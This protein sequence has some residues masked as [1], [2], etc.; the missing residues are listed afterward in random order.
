VT[1]SGPSPADSRAPAPHIVR[2]PHLTGIMA[3]IA[4]RRLEDHLRRAGAPVLIGQVGHGIPELQL[5]R[6][7]IDRVALPPATKSIDALRERCERLSG[8][9]SMHCGALDKALEPVRTGRLIRIVVQTDEADAFCLSVVPGQY[10][11]GLALGLEPGRP[12][13]D[14]AA[15]NQV[16][17]DLV[18]RWR[19][20]DLGLPSQN[21]GGLGATPRRQP[22]PPV[23]LVAGGSELLGR[24]LSR[25]QGDLMSTLDQDTVHWLALLED[26]KPEP[27]IDQFD[28][29]DVQA[30]WFQLMSPDA[31]RQFYG[32][33]TANAHAK[34]GMFA[35]AVRPVMG[36]PIRNLL[37]DVESG[38][39][40]VRPLSPTDCLV[41][42]TLDQ[43][44][45]PDFEAAM[46][47]LAERVADD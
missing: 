39:I 38:A 2:A 16:M 10:V 43:R 28:V 13:T 6:F 25:L 35:R 9:L 40:G 24:V 45:V 11:V 32:D 41:G 36:G 21:P 29:P 47:A 3:E 23:P 19:E 15:A 12:H 44:H 26:G 1:G 31:R 5:D 20:D 33:L 17:V 7:E 34:V 42:V 18:D 46:A 8:L 4:E 22:E 37:L 30:R 14:I 27:I